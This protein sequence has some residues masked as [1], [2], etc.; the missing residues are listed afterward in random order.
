MSSESVRLVEHSH[1]GEMQPYE[2][3]LGDALHGDRT[4]FG[5]EPSVEASWR[6]MDDVLDASTMPAVYDPD[7]WG[8]AEA[9]ALA[10][11]CGGWIYPFS[12]SVT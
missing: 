4:L 10:A 5:D 3:L 12:E 9:D 11:D 8:P 6:I 2:R 1:P 7:T